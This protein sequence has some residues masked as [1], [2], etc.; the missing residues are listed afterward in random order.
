VV[1]KNSHFTKKSKKM[2]Q[3]IANFISIIGHPMLAV[4][5]FALFNAVMLLE[6]YV[7][8]ITF[9]VTVL[10]S[11]FLS[12]YIFR[13]KKSGK[14]SNLDASDRGERQNKVYLPIIGVLMLTF[15]VFYTLNQPKS[16]LLAS[17]CFLLLFLLA[18]CIN[19]FIKASLH[20]AIMA[21]FAASFLQTY[22]VLGFA[23]LLFCLPLAW[24]RLFLLRHS[25]L[26][27]IIG[28]ILGISVGL[29]QANF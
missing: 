1:N 6:G 14:I 19:F 20:L 12:F 25:F 27:I 4:P 23:L 9:G 29:F 7:V 15:G 22:P 16:V 26:E 28:F 10:A 21:Y 3:K 2:Q 13:L 11:L 18:Y 17:F 5:V 8:Y 24:S